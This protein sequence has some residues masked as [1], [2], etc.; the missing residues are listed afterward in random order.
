MKRML[1]VMLNEADVLPTEI[2]FYEEHLILLIRY[3]QGLVN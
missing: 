1:A 2:L 3:C